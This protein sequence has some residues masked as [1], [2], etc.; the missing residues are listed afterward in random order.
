MIL[1]LIYYILHWL[2]CCS[3]KIVF[4]RYFPRLCV[5]SMVMRTRAVCPWL[6][7]ISL[8][9]IYL[10]I[11]TCGYLN[12]AVFFTLHCHCHCPQKTI[13]MISRHG[14]SYSSSSHYCS[15]NHY[16]I[17]SMDAPHMGCRRWTCR[18][19]AAAPVRRGEQRGDRW[20]NIDDWWLHGCLIV[21]EVRI[22]IFCGIQIVT[23]VYGQT[24]PCW[25]FLW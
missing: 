10:R 22:I 1:W 4:M 5:L 18:C 2:V 19:G 7:L 12:D 23:D 13:M 16:L 24:E 8:W 9:W 21:V 15:M 25:L 17:G 11:R 6:I 3:L 20:G 14:N